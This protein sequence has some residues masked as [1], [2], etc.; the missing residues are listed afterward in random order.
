MRLIASSLLAGLI[1]ATSGA[2]AFADQR[3]RGHGRDHDRG[4]DRGHD[5]DYRDGRRDDG[6]R[7]DDR[8]YDDRRHDDR[9]HQRGWYDSRGSHHYWSQGD[10]RGF[11]CA[12]HSHAA[13]RRWWNV[14]TPE[15]YIGVVAAGDPTE[16]SGETLDAETRHTEGLQ[17]AIR[18]R[19]GV[20]ADAI[21]IEGL[22]GLV[23]TD[24]QRVRLT[25]N[26]RLLANE[27]SLRLH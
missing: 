24:G 15:R 20:P 2:P 22:D 19:D 13:G 10:Y 25:R 9:R 23:E 1:A 3:G 18:M 4:R 27:V 11:G 7:R 12:A 6:W 5:R 16:A 17:L 8:R 26:G 14:R 21:D